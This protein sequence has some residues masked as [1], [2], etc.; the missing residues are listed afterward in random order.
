MQRCASRGPSESLAEANIDLELVVVA[1]P[2]RRHGEVQPQRADRRVVA[3]ADP[4]TDCPT[5]RGALQARGQA[6]AAAVKH[7]G[8]TLALAHLTAID[9][10]HC[11]EARSD[12]LS[13]L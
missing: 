8:R 2:E 9:E 4:D 3:A 6:A 10:G 13:E 12:A 7:A 11:P 5:G 1:A